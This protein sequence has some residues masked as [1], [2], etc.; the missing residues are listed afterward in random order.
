M[1]DLGQKN[2]REKNSSEFG[3]VLLI[4][5]KFIYQMSFTFVVD[6]ISA[7]HYLIHENEVI[8]L[9]VSYVFLVPYSLL[10]S[11]AQLYYLFAPSIFGGYNGLEKSFI[12]EKLTSLSSSYWSDN[13]N[14]CFYIVETQ[15]RELTNL[16]LFS[17]LVGILL[18][19]PREIKSLLEF[20]WNSAFVLPSPSF[21]H[22]PSNVSKSTGLT[23]AKR[24]PEA[25]AKGVATRKVNEAKKKRNDDAFGLLE[26]LLLSLRTSKAGKVA[27]EIASAY[28]QKLN[29]ILRECDN[30]IA[31]VTSFPSSSYLLDDV[32]E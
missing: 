23:P 22:F 16:V 17:I 32:T 26:A 11:M 13:S 30:K 8:K 21:N 29:V 4:L 1:T 27:M 18:V 24:N 25:I 28:E 3:F 15:I 14:V 12:C 31:S 20:I 7:I 9:V 2:R 6:V 19:R 10:F 5:K